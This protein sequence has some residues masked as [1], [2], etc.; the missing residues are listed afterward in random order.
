MQE[1]RKRNE[2]GDNLTW[3]KSK[4]HESAERKRANDRAAGNKVAEVQWMRLYIMRFL[5]L[6]LFLGFP[7]SPFRTFNLNDLWR[8]GS[9]YFIAILLHHL[10]CWQM[11]RPLV[12]TAAQASTPGCQERP[13]LVSSAAQ[14]DT[15]IGAR[16]N[17]RRRTRRLGQVQMTTH[18]AAGSR[19][20]GDEAG[21]TFTQST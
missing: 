15:E 11:E 4:L 13:P 2:C 14:T 8:H 20:I 17:R 21:S 9:E 18:G 1:T 12:W 7:E 16:T 19:G 3:S 6:L 10:H 5:L